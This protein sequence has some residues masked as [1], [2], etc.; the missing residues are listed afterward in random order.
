MLLF[1]KNCS[2]EAEELF[3]A[4]WKDFEVVSD[5]FCLAIPEIV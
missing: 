2:D 4:C 5:F 1:V 3:L